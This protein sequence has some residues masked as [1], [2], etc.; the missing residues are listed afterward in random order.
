MNLRQA[1][2]MYDEIWCSVPLA[3]KQDDFWQYKG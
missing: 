2:L 3:E 1:L